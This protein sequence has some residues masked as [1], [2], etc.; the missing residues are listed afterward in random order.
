MPRQSYEDS[1]RSGRYECR[2]LIY[3]SDGLRV[4]AYL[5]RPAAVS[6][7]ARRPVVIFNRGGNR[8]F[9]K[10]EERAMAGFRRF[11]D[12]GYIVLGSQYRGNDG[13]EG[14]EEFGGAD[15]RD[16]LNL[17]PLLAHLPDADASNVFLYGASRGGMM[18]Y[19]ALRAGMPVNAAVVQAGPVDL[20]EQ[21]RFRPGF[22]KHVYADIIP[23]FEARR[24][25]FYA[26]RSAIRW[27]EE[28]HV[29]IL[30]VQGTADWR[31]DPR[32]SLR[33]AM[34]LQELGRPYSLVMYEGDDHGIQKHREDL[35]RRVLDWFA[36]HRQ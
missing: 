8:E 14:K 30:L 10:L 1:F 36:A 16:V 13:G 22:E 25:E 7:E 15:V 32:E 29:P 17:V 21:E 12:A 5:F 20:L 11:L 27:A 6:P 28:L 4:V 35:D 24:E 18:A 3:A 34:R 33:M 31:V 26:S 2:R 19:L 23:D 9:G